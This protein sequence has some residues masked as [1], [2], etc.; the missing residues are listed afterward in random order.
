MGEIQLREATSS[1]E[2]ALRR[3]LQA[4]GLPADDVSVDR[5]AFTLAVEEG[6]IVGSVALE[7][8]GRD[9]L[10][11]S[12]AVAPEHRRHGLGARLDDRARE[13]AGRLG[14]CAL[15]LLTTTAREYALRRG[16]E[17]VP[18][19]EV[20]AGVLGLP[21]FRDLCPASATCMRWLT[22]A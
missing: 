11:R 15:Y 7:V 4:A 14:L 2:P 5:Q 9:A 19:S 13:Q 20:P 10:V 22:A 17:V 16:Y 1:D 21:Q 18:R 8:V 12:L 6:R 3:F